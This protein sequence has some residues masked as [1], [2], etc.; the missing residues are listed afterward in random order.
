M[1]LRC[2]VVFLCAAF[3]AAG[4]FSQ[5]A[6]A[7]VLYG[8]VVGIAEDPSG[9]GVP[10]GTVTITNRATG[11]T[12]EAKT[13][14]EGRYLI[15]NVLPGLYDVKITANG[16]RTQTKTDLIVEANTV[17]RGDLKLEVGSLTEQVTVQAEATLLQTD[18]SDTHSTIT[19][20]QIVN[21]AL[22][23][24]RNYQ[25]LMNLVPGAT[26]STFQ[27]SATD[28]PNRALSTHVN[29]TNLEN[30]GVPPDVYVDNTPDDFLKGRDAQLEKAVEVLK[31]EIKAG[32]KTNNGRERR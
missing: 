28:T 7:Q 10:G 16:F 20:N 26:P 5:T 18:K 31:E 15:G 24:Y 17:S 12:H 29:G 9:G 30:Y 8:S 14:G 19:G 21:L 22:P 25:S 27:N 1:T 11:Q 2:N 3:L 32:V 4:T 13:D 6:N 23:A